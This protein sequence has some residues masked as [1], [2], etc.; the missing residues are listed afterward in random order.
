MNDFTAGDTAA[1]IG[2]PG[3]RCFFDELV[4]VLIHRFNPG[5]LQLIAWAG[6]NF[7]DQHSVAVINGI[8]DRWQLLILTK[9]ALTV[10][11]NTADTQSYGLTSEIDRGS[12]F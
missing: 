3:Q 8:D 10:E 5:C 1:V 12:I 9:T 6:A 11:I 4:S 7:G 2:K